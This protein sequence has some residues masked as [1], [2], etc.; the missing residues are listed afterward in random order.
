MIEV[1][2]NVVSAHYIES[3]ET[4]TEAIIEPKVHKS[5]PVEEIKVKY[6]VNWDEYLKDDVSLI[7]CL[8]A[9]TL[10]TRNPTKNWNCYWWGA[11]WHNIQ[12]P[13][14]SH[15]ET[16]KK[17]WPD[18]GIINRLSIVNFESSFNENAWNPHAKWYVQT[19]RKYNISPDI[20]SQLGWLKKREEWNVLKEWVYW[21][22]WKKSPRCWSY[23]NQPNNRDW[24]PQWEEG[25][26]AC[27]YRH[28]YHANEWTWYA[29]K[30]MKAREFYIN[31]LM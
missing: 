5:A 19:L 14:R 3:H 30:A 20:D 7:W 2:P 16:R 11:W 28:H 10:E 8:N 17:Y 9:H 31:Y 1:D 22:Y 25:V 12:L 23:R 4:G 26:V 29:K 27:M 24:F 21:A 18:N 6:A 15:I 13:P